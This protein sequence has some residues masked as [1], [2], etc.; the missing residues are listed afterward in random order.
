MH[1]YAEEPEDFLNELRTELEDYINPYQ[2]KIT[3]HY[4]NLESE[5]SFN[6]S[7]GKKV[8]AAS[9]IKLPLAIYVMTLVD[10]GEMDLTEKLSYKSHHY[11]GGSGVIQ[12]DKIGSSYSI[13]DLVEKA[14]VYSDNI[15]FI[16]LKERVGQ[17][18]F[19]QFMKRLGAAVTYPDGQNLTSASD[20]ILYAKELYRLA[21]VSENGAKLINYLE[22][23][24][25][26]TTIPHGITGKNIAHKVGMIPKDLIYNDVALVY[27][28]QPFALAVTTEGIGYEKS[29]QVIA[30]IANIVNSHHELIVQENS[31]YTTVDVPFSK[32]ESIYY[33][34]RYTTE[35]SSQLRESIRLFDKYRKPLGIFNKRVSFYH[36]LLLVKQYGQIDTNKVKESW[37]AAAEKAK[38][39]LLSKPIRI[40]FAG[41]AMMDWSVK[42]T[43]K[44]KGPDFPFLNIKK[45][46]SLSDLSV[47]NLET[48]ITI[49]GIMVPKEYNFRSDPISLS[50]LKNAGFHLVSL[51]NNHSLDYGQSGFIETLAHLRNYQ[52]DYMGGGLNKDE[53]YSAKTYIIKGR[54]IKVLAFSRVLPDFSWVATDTKPG[55]A[56]GYDLTLIKNTI[57]QEK[58]GSDFLFV[59]IHWGVE[60]KKS[61]EVFQRDWAKTMIDSGADGV[62]GSHPH[63]LQGFEYY[64]GKPIAY[65]LGNFLFPNYVKGDKAQTGILHLNIQSNNIEMSFVPF[66]IVQDQIILQTEQE[67]QEVW[68]EL[69]TMSY[70]QLEIKDGTIINLTTIA[71][72]EE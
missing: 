35:A 41:D 72:A 5:I 43:V 23:T 21:K 19:I 36:S 39:E 16:M 33:N 57:E 50:G 52:I 15:A 17:K 61:P 10:K 28:K 6:I 55:L 11:Y 7:S 14:L 26:N 51:A 58:A 63:V 42:E 71:K 18:Q 3:L 66:R 30:D 70:G 53:A 49:G 8:P 40:T 68:D 22:N 29:Q 20:L 25:Y 1:G 13:E 62:I 64:K 54:T 38:A 32:L 48:A 65:S 37:E 67:K 69:Y 47:V 59:Y 27:D 2:G 31:Q 9:T 46:L 12:N 4:L 34:D 45:K 44:Q 24:I 56:N 60:T